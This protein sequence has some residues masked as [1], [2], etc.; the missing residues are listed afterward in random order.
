MRKAVGEKDG[1]KFIVWYAPKLNIKDGPNILSGLPGL[2]LKA[3]M[4]NPKQGIDV[5]MT[6]VKI[7]ISET[8]LN[9]EEPNKGKV[10]TE[11]EF[12]AEMKALQEKV[13]KM[14]GGGVDSE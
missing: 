5:T 3:E 9:I 4:S 12:E 13:Q 14:M 2:V 11:K 10:V 7:D 8:E 6:A 1:Q